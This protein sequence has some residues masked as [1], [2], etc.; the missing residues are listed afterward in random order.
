MQHPAVFVAVISVLTPFPNA[1]RHIKTVAIRL[2]T[3]HWGGES[4]PLIFTHPDPQL[5][6]RLRLLTRMRS[7]RQ[8]Y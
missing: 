5:Q 3:A 1:T 7:A 6:P 2:Q 4:V 8:R